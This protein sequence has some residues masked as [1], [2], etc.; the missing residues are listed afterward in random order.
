[1]DTPL[2]L[3]TNCACMYC[4]RIHLQVRKRMFGFFGPLVWRE[5]QFPEN[6]RLISVIS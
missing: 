4:R 1:M 3:S 5:A 6:N 2:L